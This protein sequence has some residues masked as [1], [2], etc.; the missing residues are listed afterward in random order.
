MLAGLLARGL[1]DDE[2]EAGPRA[3]AAGREPTLAEVNTA[4]AAVPVRGERPDTIAIFLDSP[5]ATSGVTPLPPLPPMQHV[6]EPPARELSD[7]EE[8]AIR[9]RGRQREAEADHDDRPVGEF[10]NEAIRRFRQLAGRSPTESEANEIRRRFCG[11]E[12][13]GT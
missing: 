13:T 5:P 3:R 8:A 9:E 2:P 10:I 1:R 11:E 6:G 4:V 7:D 12:A